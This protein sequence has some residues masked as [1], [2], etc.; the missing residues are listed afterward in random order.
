MKQLYI[1]KNRM[2]KFREKPNLKES[3]T[4]NL[5]LIDVSMFSDLFV[6]CSGSTLLSNN[7]HFLYIFSHSI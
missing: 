6:V 2:K 1:F 3:I 4:G 7:A 5:G